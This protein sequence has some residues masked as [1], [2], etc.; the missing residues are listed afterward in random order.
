MDHLVQLPA[1]FRFGAFEVDL[2][3]RELLKHGTRVRLQEKPFLVLV[4]L[5]RRP[6]EVVTREELRRQLWEPGTFVDFDEGVNSAVKRL[7][8]CL[9]DSADKPIYIETVARSGYRFVAPVITLTPTDKDVGQESSSSPA[10]QERG[11]AESESRSESKN[12]LDRRSWFQIAVVAG[13]LL[14][15]VASYSIWRRRARALPADIRSV[16][17]LPLRNLSGDPSQDYFADG[18]TDEITTVLAKLAG[19]RVTSRTS[20]I[21][22]KNTHKSVPE[23]AR[24]LNVGALIEGSVE[25]SGDRVRVRIQLIEASS[26]RHLWAEEYDRQLNDVLQLE[27]ELAQ[28]VAREVQLQLTEPQ[29]QEFAHAHSVNPR[30]FEN[31]LQGRQYWSLRTTD[32]LNKAVEYFRRAIE[33]DPGDARSY[34]GLAHCYI[35]MPMLTGLPQSEGFEKARDA[36]AK[37]LALD[38]SLPEAHLAS[39][40]VL[41]YHDWKFA[42]AE[43]EFV[44]TLQL[45]PSY[46]TAHQWYAEYLGLMGRYDQAIEQ[47][48]HAIVLDPLSPIVHHQA[49]NVLRDT[50]RYEEAIAEYDAALKISP[51][52]QIS[53]IERVRVFIL[54]HNYPAAIDQI[55]SVIGSYAAALHYDPAMV[56]AVEG[57]PAAYKADGEKGFNRQCVKIDHYLARPH[58]Y[59]ARDHARLGDR[60]SALAELTRSYQSHDL[61]ILWI[62]TDPDMNLLR[63]DPRFQRLVK[64]I[65]FPN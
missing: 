35:V 49:A 41:L 39:A 7:R 11:V 40:E 14:A 8:A 16:A 29:R 34:A 33:D 30:A 55:R 54:E 36:S 43:R 2:G 19:P 32:S 22:Y 53:N 45:N 4:E 18:I 59:L 50:G 64:A 9:G 25:R 60:D 12:F 5:L 48:R 21:Q 17:V 52:F 28:D 1:V 65:G 13:V 3:R 6:G 37:A 56:G 63:P 26:D 38:D 46:S 62:L 23:I 31:Y 51:S 15:S 58:Y 61:E 24:E 47:A 27:G 10:T 42:D 44:R 57:L 20:S